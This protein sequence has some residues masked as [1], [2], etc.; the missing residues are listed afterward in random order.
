MR[1][2]ALLAAALAAVAITGCRQEVP[3]GPLKLG[4][5]VSDQTSR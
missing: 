1:K 4:G 2:I 3:S 5:P